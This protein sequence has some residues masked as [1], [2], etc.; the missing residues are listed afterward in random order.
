M[1][2]HKAAHTRTSLVREPARRGAGLGLISPHTYE[3][4]DPHTDEFGSLEPESSLT[5][6][7]DSYLYGPPKRQILELE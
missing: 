5:P 7:L 6:E 3:L 4:G 1:Y 2:H